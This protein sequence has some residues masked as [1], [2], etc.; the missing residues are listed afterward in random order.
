VSDRPVFLYAAAYADPVDAELDYETLKDLHAL[1]AVGSY[2]VA[3]IVKDDEGKV[4]VHK[5]EKPTQHG[6]WA[7]AAA[8]A[9]VGILFPPALIG[10]AIVGAGAGGAIGHFWRGMSRSQ[11]KE[12]GEL[13]DDGNA[14][15]IV[16]G[17]S[18][19]EEQVQ[20]AIKHADKQLIH[21]LELEVSD[22]DHALAEDRASAGGS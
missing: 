19:V 5:R 4:H 2:D 22:L 7:G 10:T 8:G 16:I 1:G 15:L 6:A 18:K 12:V 11:M 17:E 3:V 13:L 20:K 14:A 9:V 21:Q